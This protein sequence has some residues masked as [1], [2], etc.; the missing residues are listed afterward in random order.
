MAVKFSSMQL[1]GPGRA[2]VQGMLAAAGETGIELEPMGC[3]MTRR[4]DE[5]CIRP[6]AT[7]SESSATL[8]GGAMP[9][10]AGYLGLMT[11]A[12][13]AGRQQLC[14]VQAPSKASRTTCSKCVVSSR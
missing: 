14:C 2:A 6:Q 13:V 4:R 5:N 12:T 7:V 10:S 8:A 9:L 1:R 11:A 3:A